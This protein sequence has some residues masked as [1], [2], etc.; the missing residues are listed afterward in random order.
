MLETWGSERLGL[1]SACFVWVVDCFVFFGKQLVALAAQGPSLSANFF[2]DL[3]PMLRGPFGEKLRTLNPL[4]SHLPKNDHELRHHLHSRLFH[5]RKA[6][7]K[8]EI[9]QDL[10]LLRPYGFFSARYVVCF[11]CML[12]RHTHVQ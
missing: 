2:V 1:S 7:T 12:K 3:S 5:F 11:L 9:S 10:I 8:A 6:F 4:S